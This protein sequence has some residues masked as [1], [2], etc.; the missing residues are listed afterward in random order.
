MLL[1]TAGVPKARQDPLVD[2][3][4]N[5]ALHSDRAEIYQELPLWNTEVHGNAAAI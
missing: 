4:L 1:A 3:Y 2:R 5:Y